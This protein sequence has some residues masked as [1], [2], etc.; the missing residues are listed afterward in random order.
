MSR[1]IDSILLIAIAVSGV[2]AVIAAI[3]SGVYT[4]AYGIRLSSQTLWR[5]ALIASVASALLLYRS[6]SR[7][8]KL[9]GIWSH[10]LHHST[11]LAIILGVVTVA[12]AFRVSAFE[13][14]KSDAY[15][16][17]SQ[18]QLWAAGSLV[19]QEPMSLRAPW[20]NAEWTFAPLGYRP[21]SER[22]TIV[23][24]YPPGLPLLMAPMLLL[25]GREGPFFVVP[26]LGG[27]TVIAAFLLGRRI[28]NNVCGLV[29]AALILTSPV[30]LF[31]LREPMSDVP[32][33]AWWLL[34]VL[35]VSKTNA[36]VIFAGGL[37]ASAAILTRPNLAPL[38]VVLA[39]FVL[40][41][42]A[43][44]WRRRFIHAC[45][46]VAGVIPGT[47]AVA[48]INTRLYGSPFTSGYG[49]TSTLFSFVYFW[50]NLSQYSRWLLDME[51]PLIL[52][53][54]VAWVLLRRGNGRRFSNLFLAFVVV[55][56]G[57]Y[58]LYFA[59]DNW[60]YLRFLL[61]A[62]AMLLVLC[63]LALS[64]LIGRLGSFSARFLAAAA[65]IVFCAWRWDVTGLKPIAPYDRRFAVV[66][67]YV[68]DH[69][70]ANAIVFSVDHSGS[71]RYYAAR[72]TLNWAWLPED[73]LDRSV[74]FLVSNGYQ[75]FLVIERGVE[76]ELFIQ[77][78]SG[79]STI[80]SLNMT[81][82]A[83]YHGTTSVDLFDLANPGHN[84][85]IA[86]ITARSSE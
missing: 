20:P 79:S 21:G 43:D 3:G 44:D 49:E 84:A 78:F 13:V 54:P 27:V 86:T 34:A 58:A 71:I 24:T 33:T 66:G 14:L 65:L 73:W 51:S 19:Q 61:P 47:V 85:A 80:G 39:W 26:F 17:I 76:R 63:G 15:G 36:T 8:L 35:L 67:E 5:P 62:I 28:A 29:A 82:I 72:T 32:V 40:I 53:A 77:R 57:C 38:A 23:P 1:L 22:G 30:F 48:L 55:L 2:L 9:S 83:T 25:F 45:V 81:P 12:I 41:Y 4:S 74:N 56:Y 16:Y 37:A 64:E 18:A 10:A 42:S 31:H 68:K 75:P 7:Q 6:P 59:F 52:L 46:F 60:T 70:P 11:I 69:L 50:K